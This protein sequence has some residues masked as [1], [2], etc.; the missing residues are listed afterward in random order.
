MRIAYRAVAVVLSL[1]A[2][3]AAGQTIEI[4]DLGENVLPQA[5]NNEGVVV[6]AVLTPAPIGV[7]P[8]E[9]HNGTLTIVQSPSIVGGYFSAVNRSGV[10]AGIA[11]L[12]DGSSAPLTYSNGVVAVAAV[13]GLGWA[14]AINDNGVIGGSFLPQT[15]NPADPYLPFLYSNGTLVMLPTPAFAGGVNGVNTTGNAVG[16]VTA[17]SSSFAALWTAPSYTYQQLPQI[18]GNSAAANAINESGVIAGYS[19]TSTELYPGVYEVH[20]TLW[21][22]GQVVDIGSVA[23]ASVTSARAI[24]AAEQVVGEAFPPGANVAFIYQN[25]TLETLNEL[26]GPTTGWTFTAAHGI[27]DNGDIVGYGIPPNASARHGFIL[28]TSRPTPAQMIA[29]MIASIEG[30]GLNAGIAQSL[31]AKLGAVLNALAPTRLAAC[32]EL[33]A[34]VNEVN[35][36]AGKQLT[37]AQAAELRAAA[38]ALAAAIG[39]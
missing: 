24:N 2:L 37:T 12:S 28:R 7:A 8:F 11:E 15:S 3:S 13:N 29:S 39:C 10:A 9:W 16:T 14:A 35:A 21:K 20:A 27:N 33:G 17:G 32:N 19:S 6:G 23:G 31:E 36:Q 18:G 34:F 26:A 25:G 22:N 38:A 30:Y 1:F 4:V 5:I